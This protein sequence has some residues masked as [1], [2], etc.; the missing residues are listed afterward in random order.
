MITMEKKQ[1]T[2]PDAEILSNKFED[3]I[4]ASGTKEIDAD[5]AIALQ[6]DLFNQ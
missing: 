3:I 6:T 5:E 2:A 4:V 1:Y